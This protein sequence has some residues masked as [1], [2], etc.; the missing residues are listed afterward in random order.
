VLAC[1]VPMALV[2]FTAGHASEV[3]GQTSLRLLPYIGAYAPLFEVEEM[4]SGGE[5]MVRAGRRSST[6]AYGLGLELGPATE[7]TSLR[8]QLG[9]GSDAGV[10]YWTDDCEA[11][12]ARSTILTGTVSAVLRPLPR[13]ILVQPHLVAGAGVK[14]YDME[15]RDLRG[16]D[17]SVL[18]RDGTQP[19]A[20]LGLGVEAGILGLRTQWEIS[21]F[22]SRFPS[23]EEGGPGA[24][25]LRLFQDRRLQ[26]DLFL[27]LS[28]PLGG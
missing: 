19:T 24:D 25:E 20:Q 10:P 14:R 18:F 3:Q 12:S 11:C 6:L 28:I 15:F 4:R 23:S 7:G 22:L 27:T 9:Y 2:A 26:T 13:I 8:I 16:E 5:G 17:S 21:G 1:L